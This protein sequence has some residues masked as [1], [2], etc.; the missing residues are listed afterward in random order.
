MFLFSIKVWPAAEVLCD[1]L[2][3]HK[4]LFK[5][6]NVLELGAGIGIFYSFLLVRYLRI[7]SAFLLLRTWIVWCDCTSHH[8]KGV[9]TRSFLIRR[10]TQ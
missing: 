9:K 5:D 7:V 8:L 2:L 4:P 6:K 1:Y 3:V 10:V